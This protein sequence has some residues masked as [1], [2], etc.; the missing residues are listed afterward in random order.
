VPYQTGFHRDSSGRLSVSSS[1]TAAREHGLNRL[2]TGE[3]KFVVGT[4]G[5]WS[6]GFL[7]DGAGNILVTTDTTGAAWN[8]GYLRHPSGALVVTL[9]ATKYETG[10]MRGPNGELSVSAV[11]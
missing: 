8:N 6:S 10:F 7:R 2:P 1:G 3:L 9:V 5:T 4:S 11:T